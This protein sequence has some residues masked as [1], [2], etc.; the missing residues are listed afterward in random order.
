MLLLS[1]LFLTPLIAIEGPTQKDF[2]ACYNKNSQGYITLHGVDAIAITKDKAVA[3][4]GKM[5]PK[6]YVKYDPF[7]NLYLL[8]SK[9]L[10]KPIRQRDEMSMMNKEWL[11]SVLPTKSFIGKFERYSLGM[12]PYDKSTVPTPKG[13][14]ITCTC[15]DM[16]GL[17][18]NNGRFIGNRY[19]NHFVAHDDVYY[20]DVGVRFDYKNGKIYVKSIDPFITAYGFKVGDE[21]TRLNGKPT[22]SFRSFKERIL[23]AKKGSTLSFGIKGQ[24]KRLKATVVARNITPPYLETFLEHKGMMFNENLFLRF[25]RKG[26]LAKRSGLKK[27]DKLLEIDGTPVKSVSSVRKILSKPTSKPYYLLFERQGF[28]F[29]TKIV[30]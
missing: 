11:G 6:E 3:F 18:A 1:L 5:T 20:G 7:L 15:C 22:G 19:L 30:K 8:K 27:G 10:L 14:V 2:R 25:V 12:T 26:S 16:Y 29:F 23:F 4:A 13:S 24:M 17:G 9:Q 21:I 28:Q